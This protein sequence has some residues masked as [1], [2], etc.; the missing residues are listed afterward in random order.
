ML[1][2]W[3]DL[4]IIQLTDF[5]DCLFGK[6]SNIGNI[7]LD[8]GILFGNYFVFFFFAI[9]NIE[10]LFLDFPGISGLSI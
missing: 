2:Y 6:F 1:D 8:I 9:E 3:I 7:L 4:Y 5:S 10:C